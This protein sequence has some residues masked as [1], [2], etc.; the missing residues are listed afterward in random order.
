[1]AF[2]GAR[3]RKDRSRRGRRAESLPV[4]R[5]LRLGAASAGVS[6]ALVGFSLLG[7]QTDV[8][9]ADGGG[10]ATASNAVSGDGPRAGSPG[11]GNPG[12]G[13]GLHRARGV[14]RDAVVGA[15]GR[16]ATGT[17]TDSDVDDGADVP[18][19]PDEVAAGGTEGDGALDG[20]GAAR[21][22]GR[23]DGPRGSGAERTG[24]EVPDV[25]EA[26]PPADEDDEAIVPTTQRG[27]ANNAAA[28]VTVTNTATA[29]VVPD[30]D[31]PPVTAAT[32]TPEQA[33]QLAPVVT[34][35]G[36]LGPWHDF[37]A[38]VITDTT[39]LLQS[40]IATLPVDDQFKALLEDALWGVRRTF[41]NL[42]P[43]AAP[44][45]VTGVL[46]GPITG[47]VGALDPEG[48]QVVLFIT[49]GPQFGTVELNPDGSYT[50]TPGAGFEGVDVFYVYAIDVSLHLNLLDPLRP[51]GVLAPSLI[52]QRAVTFEFLYEGDWT[53]E[54]YEQY[55][56]ALEATAQELMRYIRVSRP[57]TITYVVKSKDAD[58]SSGT[59]ASATSALASTSPGFWP[60]VVQQK[61]LTGE[62]P[63]GVES[64]GTIKWNFTDFDWAVGDDVGPG[65]YDFE[66]TAM[67]ELMHTFGFLS[68]LHAPGHNPYTNWATFTS[69][70]VVASGARP[71]RR[72][73]WDSNYDYALTSG[74]YFGGSN[75]VRA[76]G[77]PVPLY[78]PEPWREGSSATHLDDTTFDGVQ[79]PLMLMNAKTNPGPGIRE[80]SPIEVGILR[81]LGYH[82]V[83]VPLYFDDD[84]TVRV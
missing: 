65:S 11:A 45:Q 77:A 16:S 50:Y 14:L 5:W 39:A 36:L 56:T 34:A 69:F 48:D 74:L 8:A 46:S 29:N 80:L 52:N 70:I 38:T 40:W 1:M 81:D 51:L 30:E 47:T 43:T 17:D 59:L 61:L 63:N 33:H 25:A 54:D 82:A 44:V 13:K 83:L 60:T 32:I 12:A 9:V 31:A 57:V 10:E 67:H 55:R 71:F 62:D 37:A 7:P 4:R 26:E 20:A 68:Y 73:N 75:A 53:G 79:Q 76:Y 78:T 24:T 23:P 49:Q 66:S 27:T 58:M 2:S 19:V 72:N 42:A 41:F 6:A 3:S 22:D 84:G 35:G 18:D 28:N 15:G 21:V 64:D